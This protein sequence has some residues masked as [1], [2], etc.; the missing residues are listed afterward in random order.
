MNRDDKLLRAGYLIP[1]WCVGGAPAM[2]LM[3]LLFKLGVPAEVAFGLWPVMGVAIGLAV[4]HALRRDSRT[5]L[6]R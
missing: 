6:K 3:G 2:L 4:F 5:Y 1:A